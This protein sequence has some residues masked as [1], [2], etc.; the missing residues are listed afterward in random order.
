MSFYLPSV[1]YQTQQKLKHHV[2][3]QKLKRSMRSRDLHLLQPNPR[4]SNDSTRD[5]L[6]SSGSSAYR[7]DKESTTSSETDSLT[8]SIED[9]D[10]ASVFHAFKK[11]HMNSVF[12]YDSNADINEVLKYSKEIKRKHKSKPSSLGS[13]VFSSTTISSPKAKSDTK[14]SFQ[15][16]EPVQLKPNYQIDS[17]EEDEEDGGELMRTYSNV[18]SIFSCNP[19]IKEPSKLK[20]LRASNSP[21]SSYSSYTASSH[22]HESP[23]KKGHNY[24]AR[25]KKKFS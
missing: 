8:K 6:R 22:I 5:S 1:S 16:Q 11:S 21:T 23:S 17:P 2:H 13:S 25:L 20:P 4:F 12:N 24:T 14:A 18:S 9:N 7:Y 10:S 3:D 19:K 15:L